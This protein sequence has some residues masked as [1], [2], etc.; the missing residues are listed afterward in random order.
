MWSAHLLPVLTLR[1]RSLKLGL[2]V[3]FYFSPSGATVLK[4]V[5]FTEFKHIDLIHGNTATSL[6]SLRGWTSPE[7]RWCSISGIR[8][9][10][11]SVSLC[12][13]FDELHPLFL[14]GFPYL[15]FL[16]T[17]VIFFLIFQK[18]SFSGISSLL[19]LLIP[20]GTYMHGSTVHS[21]LGNFI[22]PH[23][24]ICW[25]NGYDFEIHTGSTWDLLHYMSFPSCPIKTSVC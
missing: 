14:A 23:Y 1:S 5:N 2:F 11:L 21:S 3:Y 8:C 9:H 10:L 4:L 22:H 7:S 25:F 24:S 12:R 13:I 15:V 18:I 17:L 6:A 20:R 19:S 16:I